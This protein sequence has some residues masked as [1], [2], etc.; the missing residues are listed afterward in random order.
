LA[1]VYGCV[2][3]SEENAPV[4]GSTVMLVSAGELSP[5]LMLTE[6]VLKSVMLGSS[7]VPVRSTLPVVVLASPL[8]ASLTT[9]LSVV[10]LAPCEC[11]SGDA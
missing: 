4:C 3:V 2:A 10:G 7:V 11:P 6:T 8:T 9:V 5:Q 1:S